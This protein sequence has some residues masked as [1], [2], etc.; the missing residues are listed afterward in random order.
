MIT[1]DDNNIY[2]IGFPATIWAEFIDF[3]YQQGNT[4]VGLAECLLDELETA[5]SMEQWQLTEKG[6]AACIRKNAEKLNDKK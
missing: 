1:R 3:L 6:F 4:G 5:F 2:Y